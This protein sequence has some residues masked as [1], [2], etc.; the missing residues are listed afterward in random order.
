[1]KAR[2]LVAALVV[3]V[4]GTLWLVVPDKQHPRGSLRD[5]SAIARW[6]MKPGKALAAWV[7]VEN[8]GPHTITLT[9][10]TLGRE[11][12][13]GA[14]LLGV[15]ARIG[16][17]MTIEHAYP[18]KPG[19]FLRLEGFEIPPRRGA[20]IGFGLELTRPGLVRLEDASVAYREGDEEHVLHARHTARICVAVSPAGC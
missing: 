17:V 4:G 10:A 14:K 19:P 2:E 3:L 6:T 13:E 15:R 9:D 7:L 11:L 5:D 1:V 8:R 18:G 16:E 12:P 20:T